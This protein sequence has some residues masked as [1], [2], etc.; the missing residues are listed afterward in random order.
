MFLLATQST[1]GAQTLRG[2]SP[3]IRA[4]VDSGGLPG[5]EGSY[6]PWLSETGRFVVFTSAAT[7]LVAGDTNL[8]SDVFVHDQVT[9]TTERVS[10]DSSGQEGNS[11]CALPTVSPG[12]RYVLFTSDSS[13][14]VAGDTNGS[15]DVFFHDRVTGITES[16]N[17]S[18]SGVLGDSASQASSM[19]ADGRYVG[20]SGYSTNLVAGDT[21]G[22]VDVFRR[23]RL[24]G[25]TI[26]VSLGSGGVQG[27]EGSLAPCLS[28]DGNRVAFWSLAS[29]L[30][31][32]DTNGAGDAFV[33]DLTTGV[34][35]RVSVSSGGAQANAGCGNP[36]LS[37]DGRYAA[38]ASPSSNLVPLDGNGKYDVFV[39]DL[40]SGVTTRVSVSSG[41]VEGNLDSGFTG[42]GAEYAPAL[43]ADGR[44]V[45][46]ASRASN[47]VPGDSNGKVD[48]FVHDRV[49]GTTMRASLGWRN[50]ESNGESYHIALSADGRHVAFASAGTRLVQSD[51]S[52]FDDVFVR[53]LLPLVSR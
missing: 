48:A 18:S 14:L 22:V 12:G 33:R 52:G 32:G 20:F 47:L 38:F 7:N 15:Y 27:N 21:N 30:V 17:V 43:S 4:S 31:P 26:R 16:V 3:T 25:V 45:A 2:L 19:S 39:R 51:T 29:T 49:L 50:Q 23:D 6:W 36:S 35:E 40:A 44:F 11:W 24:A 5:D 13:N 28:A 8:V 53:R 9:G 10:V 41:G 46:F 1:V 34:M 42:L 37:A